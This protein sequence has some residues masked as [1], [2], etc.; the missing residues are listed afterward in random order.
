MITKGRYLTHGLLL[1]FLEWTI[2]LDS[3][4]GLQKNVSTSYRIWISGF[5]DEKG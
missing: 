2:R 4:I 5:G 3:R 1:E